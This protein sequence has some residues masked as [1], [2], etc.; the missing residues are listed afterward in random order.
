MNTKTFTRLPRAWRFTFV[1]AFLSVGTAW[2]TA[3]IIANFNGTSS[4]ELSW[5]GGDYVGRKSTTDFNLHS[6]WDPTSMR[7]QMLLLKSIASQDLN[8]D[9]TYGRLDLEA[10]FESNHRFDQVSWRL[11]DEADAVNVMTLQGFVV[12]TVKG[13]YGHRGGN[14][15]YNAKT[16]RLVFPYGSFGDSTHEWAP[17]FEV[18]QQTATEPI[19]RFVGVLTQDAPRDFEEETLPDGREKIA[20]IVYSDGAR[21]LQSVHVFGRLPARGGPGFDAE[22]V[23]LGGGNGANEG[24]HTLVLP[25]RRA[26]GSTTA[27]GSFGIRLRVTALDP[28]LRH[29]DTVVV[30]DGDRVSVERSALPAGYQLV[31][32]N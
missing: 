16:G 18:V 30:F 22:I 11:S 4:V 13:M 15:A 25:P 9:E 28:G 8:S 20:T 10:R 27:F 19:G 3:R 2:A 23:D 1:A 12:T 5:N 6:I 21:V 29:I 17:P 14:R 31:V 24:R 32:R 26:T 7:G